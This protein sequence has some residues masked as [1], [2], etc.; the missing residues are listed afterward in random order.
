MTSQQLSYFAP[1]A[2][3]LPPLPEGEVLTATQWKT[4]MAIGDAFIPSLGSGNSKLES[5]D[6]SS[7]LSQIRGILP[8]NTPETVAQTYLAE[9]ASSTPG[10]RELLHRMFSDNIRPDARKGICVI[11]SALEYG[12]ILC[13]QHC[14]LLT[15]LA[16]G[17]DAC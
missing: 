17:L 11:L 16:P 2:S 14:M 3:P 8:A 7:A 10:A 13:K 1:L 15:V 5:S 6:Y 12:S 9:S 4:L